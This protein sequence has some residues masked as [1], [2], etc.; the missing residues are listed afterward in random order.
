VDWDKISQC[1]LN[2]KH[3]SFTIREVTQHHSFFYYQ[4]MHIHYVEH[5]IST[6]CATV[7]IVDLDLL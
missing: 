4:H 6:Q 7:G 1:L 3:F 2:I 5:I